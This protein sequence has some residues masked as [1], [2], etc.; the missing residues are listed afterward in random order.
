MQANE[1]RAA[2]A[3]HIS[4]RLPPLMGTIMMQ[5]PCVH[6]VSNFYALLGLNSFFVSFFMS[7]VL[8]FQNLANQFILITVP[9]T[10]VIMMLQVLKRYFFYRLSNSTEFYILCFIKRNKTTSFIYKLWINALFLSMNLEVLMKVSAVYSYSY[11]C[12]V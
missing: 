9:K 10:L 4:S 7:Q 6:P 2:A 12:I 11:S 5:W 3:V 1:P 8:F